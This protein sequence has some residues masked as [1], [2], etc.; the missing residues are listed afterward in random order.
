L[1]PSRSSSWSPATLPLPGTPFLAR[2]PASGPRSHCSARQSRP[3]AV[4]VP[5]PGA[6]GGR[7]AQDTATGL[8]RSLA[9]L[10]RATVGS[11][12][13]RRP[14]KTSRSGVIC[15]YAPPGRATNMTCP[16][17][18]AG[19]PCRARQRPS[20][21]GDG[22][23]RRSPSSC[24]APARDSTA[25][26]PKLGDRSHYGRSAG[27]VRAAVLPSCCFRFPRPWL[28]CATHAGADRIFPLTRDEPLE[29]TAASGYSA[30]SASTGSRRA[31][32][33][34]GKTPAS[35]PM[36]TAMDSASTT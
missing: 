5:P 34:A 29:L 18:G 7:F 12:S 35:R 26:D 11:R 32:R 33:R 19:S 14:L 10:G 13:D 8:T 4:A 15:G 17:R 30:R 6:H 25:P 27:A 31:A 1:K 16:K 21:A 36:L 2:A 24:P 3:T 9:G 20:L 23:G 22:P 28:I